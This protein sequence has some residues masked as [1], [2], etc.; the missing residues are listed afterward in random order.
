MC[1]PILAHCRLC[2]VKFLH[3]WGLET[4]LCISDSLFDF[5][6]ENYSRWIECF[7]PSICSIFLSQHPFFSVWG[8]TSYRSEFT[9]ERS[10]HKEINWRVEKRKIGPI[11][12]CHVASAEYLCES[13]R[14]RS[15]GIHLPEDFRFP[16]L[17]KISRMDLSEHFNFKV[18]SS[19][20]LI[21]L[22]TEGKKKQLMYVELW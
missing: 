2:F 19:S 11:D 5:W 3:R 14:V 1:Y 21:P 9:R 4:K 7:P 20:L 12:V 17:T 16:F 15:Q 18:K 8:C 10:Q 22:K 6:L 13:V